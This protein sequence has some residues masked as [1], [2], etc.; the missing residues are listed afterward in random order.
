MSTPEELIIPPDTRTAAKRGFVRTTAQAFAASIPTAGVSAGTLVAV[1][2][3]PDP[4]ILIC[5]AVAAIVSPLLAGAASYLS[6]LSAG[7]PDAYKGEV[8]DSTPYQA[9]H[10]AQ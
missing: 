10:G 5:T 3:D 9:K 7:I 1:V 2:Q 6:I 8:I 4:V